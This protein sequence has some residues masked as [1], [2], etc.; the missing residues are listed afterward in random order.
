M[1]TNPASPDK[2]AL[3][4]QLWDVVTTLTPEGQNASLRKAEE[5]GL[6]LNR[7]RIPF[8]ETLINLNH[9]REILLDLTEKKKLAQLPLKLQYSLLAQ[10]LRV[11]QALQALLSGTD[12][13]QAIED[14]VDDLTSSIWQYN[15][16]NLSGEVLGLAHKMNQLKAQETL[17]RGFIAKPRGF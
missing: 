8:A 10:A 6:D 16:Q 4:Q 1:G 2:S 7:G 3:S 5:Q 17:I 9:A 14:S 11:S 12:T 15:L 13:V